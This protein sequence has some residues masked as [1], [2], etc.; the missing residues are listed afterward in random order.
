[1]STDE[2][3]EEAAKLGCKVTGDSINKAASFLEK[4]GLARTE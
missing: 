1:M 3:C 4:L 2:I